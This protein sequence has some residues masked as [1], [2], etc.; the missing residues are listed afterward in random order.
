MKGR[1]QKIDNHL[2]TCP[3]KNRAEPEDNV[4]GQ[5]F[6]GMTEKNLTNTNTKVDDLLEKLLARTNL[7]AAYLQVVGNRGA[8]GIDKMTVDSLGGY[9]KEHKEEL[10]ASIKSGIYFPQPVRRVEI[11]KDNGSKRM[12]GIPTVVDRLIQQGISQILTP[13]YEPEF[14]DHSY[15]FRPQRNAHQALIKC[16]QYIQKGYKYAVDMDLE[17]FFDTVDHSKLIELL[18]HQIKDGRLISLIHRYLRAGVEIGGRTKVTT[19]GVPQGGP[20]SPLL[21]NIML[22]EL[23]KELESRG[24]KFVRYADDLMILCRSKRSASRVMESITEF[25]EGKLMLKVNR[26][27]SVV[28]HVSRIK[29]L[30]YSFYNY[31]GEARLR[32]HPKSL[33]KMKA[34]IKALTGRSKS[35]SDEQRILYLREYL[36]GWMHY[37]KLAD[38]QSYLK[39]M[40]TWYRR[41]L[42]MVKWKQWKQ[43]KTRITNLKQL[44]VN[45]YKAY[46]WANTRKSYWHTAKSWILSTTLSN[47]YLKQLGYPSLLVEYKRVRVKT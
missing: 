20:L 37:F 41:R 38:M 28:N 18:S 33:G 7:N 21:S 29:F 12:L 14:S 4:G 40:D 6:T 5:T 44:G 9:L 15:G 34:R 19:E 27:K 26:E 46:E 16:K 25:V 8:G 35:W 10:L 23:D 36:T 3:Q 11:P 39:E 31:K 43:I 1:M 17:K 2:S 47:D 30:G 24:H 45:K 22:N 13:I 42:R 32:I